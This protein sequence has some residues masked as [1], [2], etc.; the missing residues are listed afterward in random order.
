MLRQKQNFRFF[1]RFDKKEE[2]K[3]NEK[4]KCNKKWCNI[5]F[6]VQI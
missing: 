5:L 2:K 4:N 6:D 3:V 1:G